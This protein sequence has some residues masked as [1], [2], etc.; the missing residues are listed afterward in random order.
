MTKDTVIT[1]LKS[2][3]FSR[4]FNSYRRWEDDRTCERFECGIGDILLIR[5]TPSHNQLLLTSRLMDVE[6][7]LNSKDK[8]FP[9]QNAISYKAYGE[10][11]REEEGNQKF[12]D[13]IE[14]YIKD[15]YHEDSFITCDKGMNLLDGNHRMGIHIHQ[16]IEKVNVRRIHRRISFERGGDWYYRV[17]LESSF[18]DSI[19]N[20]FYDIQKWLI[21]SG[22]TFCISVRG[23]DKDLNDI[24]NDVRHLCHVLKTEKKGSSV[25]IQFSMFDP[26]YTVQNNKLISLRAKRIGEIITARQSGNI[27]STV[28]LNCLEGKQIFTDFNNE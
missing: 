14:S 9:R 25:L 21:E 28:S 15:G 13:L 26:E 23:G 5:D 27:V 6:D 8:S 17:G 1:L 22:N 12:R 2:T 19:Y 3:G 11:H 20:R 10:S 7:Y 18:M 16:G 24:E 4:F